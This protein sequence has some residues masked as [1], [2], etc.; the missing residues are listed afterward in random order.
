MATT[1]TEAECA[2]DSLS[3]ITEYAEGVELRCQSRLRDCQTSTEA[4]ANTTEKAIAR[5][6]QLTE[7]M[8][9]HKN[10]LALLQA[11]NDKKL[12]KVMKGH[13]K[14]AEG[15]LKSASAQAKAAASSCDSVTEL[16]S[17]TTKA[18]NPSLKA[19]KHY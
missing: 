17:V 7:E 4:C 11:E 12:Q 19:F 5:V 3:A 15:I 9:S 16:S 18:A 14:K 8:E 1:I 6:A 2:R 13:E 10:T